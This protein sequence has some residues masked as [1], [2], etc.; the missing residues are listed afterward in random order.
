MHQ[1]GAAVDRHAAA[2]G[3]DEGAN[4]SDQPERQHDFR[5]LEQEQM[6]QIARRHGGDVDQ[7][8]FVQFLPRLFEK[9]VEI[10]RRVQRIERR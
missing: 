5:Q 2:R 3:G 1:R 8:A 10:F 4:S 9:R 6:R 7:P